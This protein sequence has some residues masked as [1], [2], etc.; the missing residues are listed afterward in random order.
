MYYCPRT[1]NCEHTLQNKTTLKS[2]ANEEEKMQCTSQYL[3]DQDSS[4]ETKRLPLLY[5]IT[6]AY[7]LSNLKQDK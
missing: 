3:S 6:H 4:F 2:Q 5:T 7:F 1:R